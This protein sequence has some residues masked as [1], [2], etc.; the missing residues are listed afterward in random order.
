MVRVWL[1]V[2]LFGGCV[3]NPGFQ[4]ARGDE[5]TGLA[6]TSGGPTT[7]LTG[8]TGDA[9]PT[10]EGDGEATSGERAST[11][12]TSTGGFVGCGDGIVDGDEECDAGPA[13][14]DD[15]VCT[16]E[17]RKAKCGDGLVFTKIDDGEKCDDGPENAWE[18]G[19]CSPDCGGR[20][21][22][23]MRTIYLTDSKVFGNLST[24]EGTPGSGKDAGDV[25]CAALV[26]EGT[27]AMLADGV[28]R[29]ATIDPW[30]GGDQALDWVLD[31]YVGYQN[32]DG[33]PLGITGKEA[34]LGVRNGEL[35]GPLLNEIGP[36]LAARTG[37]AA[38]WTA[39]DIDC[40]DWQVFAGGPPF[41]TIGNAALVA[42]YLDGAGMANCLD[43]LSIYCVEQ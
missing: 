5:T 33:E 10:S 9:T 17:C 31:P 29:R 27:K 25:A 24:T 6:S 2:V 20:I 23:A 1:V 3:G 19:A 35:T 39:T 12:G 21:P 32:G 28:T 4:L 26:G 41:S 37:M 40:E 38:D 34:L 22:L 7:E 15:A 13:N 16:S 36:E 14:S 11:S 42:G 43:P 18:L 30:K 8:E